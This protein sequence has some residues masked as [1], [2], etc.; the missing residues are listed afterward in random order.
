MTGS[1]NVPECK[2]MRYQTLDLLVIG[3]HCVG[4][5]P[6]VLGQLQRGGTILSKAGIASKPQ[7]ITGNPPKGTAV[8]VRRESKQASTVVCQ[9][10]PKKRE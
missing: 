5:V 7:T 8:L 6:Q 3:Q 2:A 10:Q 9:K 4:T 1:N